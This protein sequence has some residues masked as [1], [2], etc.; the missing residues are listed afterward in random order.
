MELGSHSNN[1]KSRNSIKVYQLY[2]RKIRVYTKANRKNENVRQSM[3]G[4][5]SLCLRM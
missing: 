5:G 4:K 3:T 2:K 1:K